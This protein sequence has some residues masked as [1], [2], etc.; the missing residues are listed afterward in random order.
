MMQSFHWSFFR[1]CTYLDAKNV[2]II[3]E[4]KKH[5]KYYVQNNMFIGHVFLVWRIWN[6]QKFISKNS[7]SKKVATQKPLGSRANFFF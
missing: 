2:L 3:F 4:A 5:T 7:T 6:V 1:E